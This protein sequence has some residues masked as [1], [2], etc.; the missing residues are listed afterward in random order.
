[1]HPLKARWSIADV[2]T[3]G[4]RVTVACL[5]LVTVACGSASGVSTEGSGIIPAEPAASTPASTPPASDESLIPPDA[6][7][8]AAA[9][10]EHAVGPLA[11]L[12][13]NPDTPAPRCLTVRSSQRLRVVNTSNHFGQPGRTVTVTFANFPPRTLRVGDA[14]TFDRPFGE[15]LAPGVHFAHI[16]LYAGGGGE[17]LLR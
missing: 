17:V 9:I 6:E 2:R 10:C 1:L 4:G 7:Q 13:V 11:I 15:Y 14:T 3:G 12:L 8:P 5:L 16:S